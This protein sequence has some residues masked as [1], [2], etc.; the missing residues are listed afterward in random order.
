M[1]Q[2]R[3]K[4]ADELTLTSPLSFRL[5]QAH[6]TFRC[7]GLRPSATDG[8]DRTLSAIEKRI[9]SLLMKS[10]KGISCIVWS[11]KVPGWRS[12]QLD[13]AHARNQRTYL[14]LSQPLFP[15]VRFLLAE[16]ELDQFS[17]AILRR[18]ERDHVLAHL[19][20]VVS[21]V[22]IRARTQPLRRIE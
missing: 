9:S 13:S 6:I 21:R 5:K 22:V 11:R 4:G 2:G 8:M 10:E 19:L 14:A 18:A 1:R 12:S 7:P 16:C 17:V 3:R 15:L 20:E